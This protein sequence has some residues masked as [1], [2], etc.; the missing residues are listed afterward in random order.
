MA[1]T[2]SR[3][4]SGA[5]DNGKRG[6][7]RDGEVC[8]LLLAEDATPFLPVADRLLRMRPAPFLPPAG[9]RAPLLISASERREERG[10][11]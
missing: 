6:R 10:E 5:E 2:P 4:V 3:S 1:R 11:R 9:A 8:V 7:G